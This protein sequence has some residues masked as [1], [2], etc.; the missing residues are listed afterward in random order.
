[1]IEI[2]VYVIW[3]ILGLVILVCGVHLWVK[4]ERY[5][6]AQE[7]ERVRN[8]YST[9]YVDAL[10]L[11]WGKETPP[12]GAYCHRCPLY[13][14]GRSDDD[15]TPTN[16]GVGGADAARCNQERGEGYGEH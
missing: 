5:K 12:A 11:Q 13:R 6:N 16:Y 1:M 4:N 7:V 14:R 9:R 8:E 10:R 2:M 15:Y 3:A